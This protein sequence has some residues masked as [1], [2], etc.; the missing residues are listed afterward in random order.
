MTVQ[1]KFEFMANDADDLRA[2]M[3]AVLGITQIGAGVAQSVEPSPSAISEAAGKREDE[4]RA[5]QQPSE[6]EIAKG[7]KVAETIPNPPRKRGR[8]AKATEPA[9]NIQA[10]PE[11]RV[12]PATEAQ[13]AADEKATQ[14]QGRPLSK[15]DVRAAMTDYLKKYGNVAAMEDGPKILGVPKISEL[16]D[17]QDALRKAVDDT[18]S[19]IA[20]NPFDRAAAA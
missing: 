20:N 13:D 14:E 4:Q 18:L 19:A 7:Q 5:V 8:P 12:D 6:P 1:L 11:N 3:L 16:A 9:P 15:D 10:E 2:Q 17:T